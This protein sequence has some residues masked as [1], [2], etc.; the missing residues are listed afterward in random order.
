[1]HLERRRSEPVRTYSRGMQQRLSIARA[2]LHNPDI[3][4]M[5]EP[6]TGLDQ[7]SARNVDDLILQQAHA[8]KVVLLTSHDL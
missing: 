8:G 1:M 5:D 2:I 4:L 6:Y 7:D 3:L